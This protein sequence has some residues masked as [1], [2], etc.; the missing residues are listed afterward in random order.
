MLDA[1]WAV[2]QRLRPV[3][4][5][6]VR[7]ELFL[8]AFF[9]YG[10]RR[11]NQNSGREENGERCEAD[12]HENAPFSDNVWDDPPTTGAWRP[13]LLEFRARFP[14]LLAL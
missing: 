1:V 10:K 2:G 5:E 12:T 7:A 4:D 8:A 14:T 13:S 3:L 6:L 11:G 9:L